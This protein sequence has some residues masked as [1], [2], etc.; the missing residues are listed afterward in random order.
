MIQQR[1]PPAP[2]ASP[3]SR[4]H[5]WAASFA[6]ETGLLHVIAG[7]DHFQEWWGYGVFFLVV[8]LCQFVGG[9]M[10]LF[11]SGRGLYWAGIAGTVVVLAVWTVSRTVG[12][13]IGPDSA[14]P[15]PIGLLDALCG[16]LEVALVFFL[17]R[18]LRDSAPA[19][20]ERVSM[21]PARGPYGPARGQTTGPGKL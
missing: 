16:G 19:P 11:K 4:P 14:A 12:V 6:T 15:E 18:L 9:A 17:V 10:L 1:T 2:A 3:I 7:Q 20:F 5:L 13:H 8:S 21:G